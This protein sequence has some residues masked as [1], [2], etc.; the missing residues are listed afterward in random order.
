VTGA[1]VDTRWGLVQVQ[2]TVAGGQV[3]AA[4]AVR[5]PQG[6]PRDQQINSF[7]IPTLN[8][9]AVT[10]SSATIHMVSGATYTSTGYISSL[11]SALNK[12]GI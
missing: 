2:I 12:A 10:A 4:Q 6:T 8:A 7:A 3:T 9:E 1:S 11:Q 5:C